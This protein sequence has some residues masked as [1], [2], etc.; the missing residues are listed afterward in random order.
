VGPDLVPVR[1]CPECG[2]DFQP[3][4]VNCSDCGVPLEDAI[5]GQP[6]ARREAAPAEDEGTYVAINGILG[7]QDVLD[8][9]KALSAT[10]LRYQLGP[11]TRRDLWALAVHEADAD[12]AVALLREAGL[13]PADDDSPPVGQEGGPCPACGT[14]VAA[15]SV[16]CGECGLVVGGDIEPEG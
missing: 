13:L 14:R 1:R 12:A 15:G 9:G 6:L 7:Q 5:E 4:I 8:A 16:E 11:T 2:E 10:A 3:H